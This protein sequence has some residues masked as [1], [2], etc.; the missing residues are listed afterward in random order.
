MAV[1]SPEPA[2]RPVTAPAH[3]RRFEGQNNLA[4]ND[5]MA[6]DGRNSA[7]ICGDTEKVLSRFPRN[8]AARP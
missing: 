1:P 2:A 4:I 8:P 5:F 7:L 3:V 6:N